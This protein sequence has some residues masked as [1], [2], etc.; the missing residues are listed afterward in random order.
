MKSREG[1]ELEGMF[2]AVA[3]L[4]IVLFVR[5]C[6]SFITLISISEYLKSLAHRRTSMVP[7]VLVPTEC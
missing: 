1:V 7:A 6:L 4:K 3:Y 2:F 5:L